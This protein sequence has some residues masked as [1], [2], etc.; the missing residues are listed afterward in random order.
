VG[1]AATDEKPTLF[2]GIMMGNDKLIRKQIFDPGRVR[3]HNVP[4]PISLGRSWVK[5]RE[6][7][8]L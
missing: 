6:F 7:A 2:P 5:M 4:D 3:Y 1:T 8:S